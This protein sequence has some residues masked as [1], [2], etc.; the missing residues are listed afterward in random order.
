MTGFTKLFSSITASTIWCED[1]ATRIVWVTML[2][3]ADRDGYV[4]AS[5]PGLA[6]IARVTLEEVEAALEKFR[7][8]DRYS[9]SREHEGRRIAD[10]DGGWMLLNY[11]KYREER[12][13]EERREKNA[14]YQRAHRARKQSSAK[15]YSSASEPYASAKNADVSK[16]EHNAEAEAEAETEKNPPIPSLGGGTV[17]VANPAAPELEPGEPPPA[18]PTHELV[19]RRFTTRYAQ[20]RANP[21]SWGPKQLEHARTLAQWLDETEGDAEV[22]LGRLLD[23]FFRDA[24]AA[25]KAFPLGA[26]AGNPSKY[27]DAPSRPLPGGAKPIREPDPSMIVPEWAKHIPEGV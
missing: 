4:A 11:S 15:H 3:M 8:P 14:R 13:A 12:D 23:G 17:R 18:V 16:S 20:A 24:W 10:V 6:A 21:P 1:H 2:A 27:L 19:R 9:R 5:V 25:E 7:S 22:L 26:L